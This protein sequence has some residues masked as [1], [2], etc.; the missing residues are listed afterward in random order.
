MV[1]S[2]EGVCT[3]DLLVIVLEFFNLKDS[4]LIIN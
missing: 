1:K 4:V 2:E 3:V